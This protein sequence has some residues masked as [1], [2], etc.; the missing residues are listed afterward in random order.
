MLH[1]IVGA[2]VM[3][4]DRVTHDLLRE[5]HA[6]R[7][8]VAK[9]FGMGV[10]DEDGSI[11]R[12]KL[13]RVVFGDPRALKK[14][15]RILHPAVRLAIRDRLAHTP[16]DAVVVVDAVKLLDG[17]LGSMA[18]SIWWVTA[19]PEQ[20]VTRLI[21]SRGM[22]EADARARLAA[23]PKLADYQDRVNVII[24]NSGTLTETRSQVCAAVEALHIP[25]RGAMHG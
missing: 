7:A 9:A 17:D 13:G 15:E 10:F 4:A 20:Q 22:T 6:V 21:G 5:D 14:L 12:A 8:A 18:H 25:S 2:V 24:D 1:E 11:E 3:D 16:S 19:T 23:Q